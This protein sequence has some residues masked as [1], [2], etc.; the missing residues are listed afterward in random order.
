VV[1]ALPSGVAVSPRAA[2]NLRRSL[3]LAIPFGGAALLILALV[4][5]PLAGVFV[6]L[7]LGFG[8]LNARL[9]QRAVVRYGANQ[10]KGGFV[11][12]MLGRLFLLTLVSLGAV[13][14]IRPDGAGVL[15]GIAIFQVIVLL[16]AAIPVFRDLRR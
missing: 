11:G 3:V 16:G 5:H 4:G 8:A 9:V 10:S 7:G 15:V 12:Q 14:L 1:N 6:V 2:A 13:F